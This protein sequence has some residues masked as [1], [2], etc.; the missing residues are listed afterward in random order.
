M[1]QLDCV[2]IDMKLQYYYAYIDKGKNGIIKNLQSIEDLKVKRKLA[3]E[4]PVLK[5]CGVWDK[6]SLDDDTVFN[7]FLHEDIPNES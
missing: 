2:N 3:S 7:V 4:S 5:Y 6:A 1:E